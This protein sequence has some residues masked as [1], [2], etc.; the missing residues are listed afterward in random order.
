MRS[1]RLVPT[2]IARLVLVC[3]VL[4]LLSAVAGLAFAATSRPPLWFLLGF[5]AM[6]VLAAVFGVLFGSG[7]FHDGPAICLLC[8]AGTIGLCS[9]LGFQS[10]RLASSVDVTPW[11]IARGC[12]AM[13]FGGLAALTVIVRDPRVAIPDLAKAGA[14]GGVLVLTAVALW[15]TRGRIG[16]MPGWAEFVVWLIA[17]VWMLGLLAPGVHLAIRGFARADQS[18]RTPERP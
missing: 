17:G 7:R 16:S 15:L 9:L 12:A 18:G 4:L 10:V 11:F 14:L 2:W 8:I 3:S 5:E 6:I 13:V 1:A